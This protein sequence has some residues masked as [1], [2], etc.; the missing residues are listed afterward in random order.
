LAPQVHGGA[1]DS[2]FVLRGPHFVPERYLAML[3]A[4]G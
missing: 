4:C 3:D 2:L 1:F